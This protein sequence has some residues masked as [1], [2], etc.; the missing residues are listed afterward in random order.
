MTCAGPRFTIQKALAIQSSSLLE[1]IRSAFHLMGWLHGMD[2]LMHV[3][4]ARLRTVCMWPGMLQY[5]R[6]T[7]NKKTKIA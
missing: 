7:S 3:Y 5:L 2:F 4:N 6:L 1:P